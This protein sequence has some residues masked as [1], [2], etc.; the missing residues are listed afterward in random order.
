MR[1]LFAKVVAFIVRDHTEA[2]S[3]RLSFLLRFPRA[4]FTVL[5]FYFLSGLIGGTAN[6]H[7]A[8]FGGSYFPWVLVGIALAAYLDTSLTTFAYLIRNAQVTGTMEALLVTQT[9]LPTIIL[10]SSIYSFVSTSAV[11]LLYLATGALF[12]GVDLGAANV[13][14]A[15]L[16]LLLSIAAFSALGIVSAAFTVVFKRGEAILGAFTQVSFLLG[17]VYFPVTVLPNWLQAVAALLPITHALDAMRFALL[18]P[19]D[20][21]GMAAELAALAVFA[22]IALPLSV[23]AFDR[24][25]RHAKASGSL[26]Q[27]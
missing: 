6:P 21:V 1:L 20:L 16:V 8:A 13:P 27:Y 7:L 3:Y 4:L 22:L 14:A 26:G 17:G 9:Q 10:G 2:S 18:R 19:E 12:F 25:V 23:W 24:A 11:V 5:V 15:A